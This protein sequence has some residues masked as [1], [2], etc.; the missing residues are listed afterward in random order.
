V[1]K[2][3]RG[4]GNG[5]KCVCVFDWERKKDSKRERGEYERRKIETGWCEKEVRER[6]KDIEREIIREYERKR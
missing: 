1:S 6:E 3:E 2:R 4:G 5:W